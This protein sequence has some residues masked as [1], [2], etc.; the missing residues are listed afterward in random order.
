MI[1]HMETETENINEIKEKENVS[2][3]QTPEIDLFATDPN[4]PEKQKIMFETLANGHRWHEIL[5]S[6]FSFTSIKQVQK[7]IIIFMRTELAK[8]GNLRHITEYKSHFVNYIQA[9]LQ[10]KKL[11]ESERANKL[12]Q[13]LK[14]PTP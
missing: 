9:K 4:L 11:T 8:E 13:M 10:I 14:Q 12:A 6:E 3:F 1:K 5:F 7:E 2:R